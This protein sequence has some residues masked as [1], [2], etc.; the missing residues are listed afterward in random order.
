MSFSR[1]KLTI[2][3]RKKLILI[4]PSIKLNP[5]VGRTGAGSREQISIG[6]QPGL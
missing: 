5:T 3:I 6:A 4:M 2:M 1:E